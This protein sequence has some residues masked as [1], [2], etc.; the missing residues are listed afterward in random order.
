MS[1][2]RPDSGRV[3]HAFW[4]RLGSG[5]LEPI[6]GI[7]SRKPK[8]RPWKGYHHK[9][10]LS[11]DVPLH[12]RARITALMHNDVSDFDCF[13]RS[14]DL[15]RL[16]SL[17]LERRLLNL[18]GERERGLLRVGLAHRREGVHPHV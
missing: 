16:G 5:C 2:A 4:A 12:L 6:A 15:C 13:T 1:P 10:Y 9:S 17:Q 14:F 3:V 18:A 8:W 7:E 11:S